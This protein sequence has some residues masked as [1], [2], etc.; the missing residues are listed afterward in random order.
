LSLELVELPELWGAW[1]GAASP[2]LW[3]GS[4]RDGAELTIAW[5]AAGDLL[6][7]YDARAWFHLDPEARSLLSA[8]EEPE[9]LDWR[10][11]LLS[12]VLPVVALVHRY[13]ALHAAAVETP[14]GVV[15]LL[16]PS[17][18]G[19]STLA[20]ELLRRGHRLFADDVT[21]LAPG[22]AGPLAHPAGP[23]L[24]V[25]E[26]ESFPG[27]HLAT[28]GGKA[29]IAVED[30]CLEPRPLRALALLRR[31]GSGPAAAEELEPSPLELAP[32]MVGLPDEEGRDAARFGL[33]S[34]LVEGARLLRLSGSPTE[35][36]AAFADELERA[37][38]LELLAS[39]GGQR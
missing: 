36:V 14:A 31:G 30:A 9:A 19:K 1:S 21:V 12:R 35:P 20:T 18:A 38:G 3:R 16:G 15:A 2:S 5:G 23:Y 10:R 39:A 11:V 4:L 17:G 7:G 22:P 27:E 8:A 32:F 29:W 6:F 24:S 25:G 13:E 26:D 28:L 33:Y 37:L 34:D